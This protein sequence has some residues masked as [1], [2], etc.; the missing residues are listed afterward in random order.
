MVATVL[1]YE[2]MA[3]ISPYA[4]ESVTKAHSLGLFD[5]LFEG[6]LKPGAPATRAETIELLIRF[7]SVI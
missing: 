4:L 7:L 6:N 2:D 3:D 1:P 5:G